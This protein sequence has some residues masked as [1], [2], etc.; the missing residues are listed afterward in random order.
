LRT[1]KRSL[2]SSIG[3]C[4]VTERSSL[5]RCTPP[6]RP[7]PRSPR[8]PPP[9]AP[10]PLLPPPG[11]PP[12][13][14]RAGPLAPRPPAP[15]PSQAP[16][17]HRSPREWGPPSSPPLHWKIQCLPCALQRVH[18]KALRTVVSTPDRMSQS[19]YACRH[20]RVLASLL[21][22]STHRVA[23]G[24]PAVQL[25]AEALALQRGHGVSASG[26]VALLARRGVPAFPLRLAHLGLGSATGILI[27]GLARLLV[28][29]TELASR[30]LEAPPA[31]AIS[32]V[33]SVATAM[34]IGCGHR[35]QPRVQL[36]AASVSTCQG[37]RRCG[38]SSP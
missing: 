33:S 30:R 15:P 36:H 23:V 35:L 38:G 32:T 14:P 26:Q 20:V 4:Q 7:S 17:P 29:A 34:A 37:S 16:R 3:S 9:A 8:W 24:A 27:G 25:I 1:V 28:E 31:L 21:T 22:S 6:P 5:P 19:C 18:T 2:S 13:A 10:R 12:P 11:L